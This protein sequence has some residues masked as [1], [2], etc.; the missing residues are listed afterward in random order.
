MLDL[1]GVATIAAG[2]LICTGGVLA[3]LPPRTRPLLM[4]ALAAPLPWAIPLV[5]IGQIV[6]WLIR[7]LCRPGLAGR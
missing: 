2:L 6:S 7:A 1:I 4:Y 3:A 5:M